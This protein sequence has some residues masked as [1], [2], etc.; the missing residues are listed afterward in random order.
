MLIVL[1][2]LIGMVAAFGATLLHFLVEQCGQIGSFVEQL[3]ENRDFG[4]FWL[5]AA[6]LLPL[7][8]MGL[9]YAVQR[10]LGGVFYAKSLSPLIL[11]LSRHRTAIPLRETLTHLLSS[12]FAV[13]FGGAAGLEAPSVLT[14]GAI[15]ANVSGFLHID[16]R[17]R[18]LLIGCGAASAIS[19]IFSSP[20]G[21]V[22]FA[23]EVLLPEFSVAALI[24]MLISSAT[25]MVVSRLIL[26]D[27]AVPVLAVTQPWENAAV[28][29]YFLLSVVSAVIGVY[30]IKTASKLG[31]WLHRHLPHRRNRLLIC[32]GVLCL[33]LWVFPLLRG[34]GYPFISLLFN[35]RLES[36]GENTFWF[37]GQSNQVWAL[38][39]LIG[40]A[41][42]LKVIATVLT[43]DGGGDGGIFAPS[44]F[45][46]AFCGFAFARLINLSGL[47]TLHE[48]NFVVLGMCGVFTAVIRAPLTGIF[49]IAE[50]TGGYLLLVPLMIVSATAWFI[51]RIFEPHSIYR[52]PLIENHLLADNRDQAVL[53]RLPVRLNL[54]KD[55]HPIKADDRVIKL[56]SMLES[57]LNPTEMLPVLDEFGKLLGIVRLDKIFKVILDPDFAKAL[58]VYD[59]MEAPRGVMSP[60]D[61][62]SW[63]MENLERYGFEK[64][65]VVDRNGVFLGFVSHDRIFKKYRKLVMESS[66]F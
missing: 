55:C 61:D 30:V 7:L 41:V 14:G 60:E 19:A 8:G 9:S 18:S 21:G 27:A 17:Y 25:A 44:M 33:L 56:S 10:G 3:G 15:G 32:G 54:E 26:P 31:N 22:L 48:S 36:L 59:L 51:A 64:L 62:L 29:F 6:A 52:K 45:I 1:S 46:G 5:L 37:A 24:P 53:K 47:A 57:D 43:V 23:V 39:L 63:A 42:L 38:P 4:A 28:P 58:L 20:I 35:H 11:A 66:E 65:P 50:V 12:G 49:L 13:G 16:R 40:A 2:M 34:Q